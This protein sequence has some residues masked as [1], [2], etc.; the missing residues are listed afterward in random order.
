[1]VEALLQCEVLATPDCNSWDSRAGESSLAERGDFRQGEERGIRL[2]NGLS[3]GGRCRH[4]MLDEASSKPGSMMT[5]AAQTQRTVFKLKHASQESVDTCTRGSGYVRWHG[6][7]VC[8]RAARTGIY[9]GRTRQ[10]PAGSSIRDCEVDLQRIVLRDCLLA[11]STET[12]RVH[13]HRQTEI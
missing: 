6:E 13:I 5:R 10:K 9:G 3:A 2:A 11:R 1:M 8:R 12:L 7:A 4:R